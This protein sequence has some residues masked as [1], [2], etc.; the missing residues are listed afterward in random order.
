[1]FYTYQR[2]QSVFCLWNVQ[3]FSKGYNNSYC[4]FFAT[5]L[6][7]QTFSAESSSILNSA[8]T[9][10]KTIYLISNMETYTLQ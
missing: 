8:V 1:M 2:N 7:D 10:E 5:I 9:E 4:L 6:H 3:V